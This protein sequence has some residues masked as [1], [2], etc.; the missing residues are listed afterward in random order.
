[1]GPGK[2]A[3]SIPKALSVGADTPVHVMDDD[4]AGSDALA[5]SLV[6]SEALKSIGFD[7][8]IFG[9]ESTVPNPGWS[10]PWS[11]S[12]SGHRN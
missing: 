9:S 4:L 1:M 2:A 8:V 11:P 3:D 5:T 12:A 6:L 7:L 10:R